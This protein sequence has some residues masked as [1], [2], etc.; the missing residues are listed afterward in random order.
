MLSGIL[1]LATKRLKVPTHL[2]LKQDCGHLQFMKRRPEEELLEPT[3]AAKPELVS[4]EN[5]NKNIP[6]LRP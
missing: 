2:S 6:H 5:K 3:L 1:G 4:H